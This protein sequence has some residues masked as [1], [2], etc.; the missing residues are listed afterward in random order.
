MDEC[1]FRWI[2]EQ[3]S[4]AAGVDFDAYKAGTL[5]RRVAH[6][7]ALTGCVTLQDYRARIERGPAEVP[8]LLD[9]LLIKTTEMFRGASTTR[10]LRERALPELLIRRA[11]EGAMELRAWVPACATGEEAFSLAMGLLEARERAGVA[12]T[13]RVLASDIDCTAL[14]HAARGVLRPECITAVPPDLAARWLEPHPRGWSVTGEARAAV[15]VVR[16]D[17]LDPHRPTPPEAVLATFDVVSCR[18]VLIYLKPEAQERVVSRLIAA[19]EPG[20]LLVLGES[21]SPPLVCQRSLRAVEQGVPVF[22]TH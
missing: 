18:N 10:V 14:E 8:R 9:A 13:V 16:H 4:R 5:Q 15:R 11:R 3:A 7:M 17:L 20:S 19:C 1:D 12:L 22:V 6:R 21:E 2:L